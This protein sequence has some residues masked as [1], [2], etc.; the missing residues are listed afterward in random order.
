M[1]PFVIAPMIDVSQIGEPDREKSQ[2]ELRR[3]MLDLYPP[4]EVICSKLNEHSELLNDSER[5]MNLLAQSVNGLQDTLI[6]LFRGSPKSLWPLNCPPRR[7]QRRRSY[8]NAQAKLNRDITESL[9]RASEEMYS[10]F[11]RGL[12]MDP[13]ADFKAMLDQH[14]REVGQKVGEVLRD[15]AQLSTAEKVRKLVMWLLENMVIP[16]LLASLMLLV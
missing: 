14:T 6:G 5:A 8:E 1:S 10:G 2:S 7:K 3:A 15:G 13:K 12:R 11:I 16:L 9:L 4:L